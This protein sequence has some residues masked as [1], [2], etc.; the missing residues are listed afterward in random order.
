[1][2][3]T[4]TLCLLFAA[5]QVT[6]PCSAQQVFYGNEASQKYPYATVLRLKGENRVPDYIQFSAELSINEG[7]IVSFLSKLFNLST[8]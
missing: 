4:F 8:D 6:S 1:M 3:I 5:L 7:Q 2:K